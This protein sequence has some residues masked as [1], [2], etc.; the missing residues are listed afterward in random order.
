[1]I[2]PAVVRVEDFIDQHKFSQFQLLVVA[3]CTLIVFMDG[4][5]TQAIGYVAPALVN[6][7]HIQRS[8]LGP[9]FSAG[10]IGLMIGALTLG[11]AADR[12]G[13]KPVLLASTLAFGVCSLLTATATSV[14]ELLVYRLL[15][16]FGLGGAM[17]NAI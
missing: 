12:I 13:R 14:N 1:M 6:A 8:T 9:I 17:P 5:D 7:W 16:G 15:T 11:P 2:T 10:L 4:Y 3:L